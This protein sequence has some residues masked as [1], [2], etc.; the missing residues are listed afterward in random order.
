MAIDRE[1]VQRWLEDYVAA[2]ETYDHDRIVALF[3]DD[4][5]YRWHPY[6]DGDDVA[7]GPEAIAAGWVAPEALDQPG[8]YEGQYRPVAV[9]GDVAVAAG[10][11][12]YFTD[13]SRATLDKEYHNVF[14]LRFGPDGRCASFTEWYMQ[15]PKG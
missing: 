15:T 11:S 14:V 2:W 5:E 13:A 4:A 3:A 1:H 8:T 12:R 9:D 6:D 10:V 7:Y